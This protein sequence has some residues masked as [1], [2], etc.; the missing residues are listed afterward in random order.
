LGQ[1]I[2]YSYHNEYKEVRTKRKRSDQVQTNLIS[3]VKLISRLKL[4][5]RL[6]K[7]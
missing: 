5:F 4:N 6:A 3:P 2:E 7:T 1:I